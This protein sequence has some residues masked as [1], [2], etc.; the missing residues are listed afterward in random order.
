M[1]NHKTMLDWGRFLI[2]I[3]SRYTNQS[4]N[5]HPH[6]P[7]PFVLVFALAMSPLGYAQQPQQRI[8]KDGEFLMIGPDPTISARG[9]RLIEIF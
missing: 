2:T 6:S 8:L 3:R 1:E 5:F 4:Q 7:L 9:I